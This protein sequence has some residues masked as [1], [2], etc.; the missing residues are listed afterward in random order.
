M[1][2]YDVNLGSLLVTTAIGLI[3]LG[4]RKFYALIHA[5]IQRHD[6]ALDD[7]DD[8]AEILNQHTSLI[9]DAGLVKGPLGI[10][11]VDERRRR[12]RITTTDQ[13]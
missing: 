4:L 5:V 12:N 11:R 8:H 6:Q 7:I 1:I 2:I 13:N 9:V 3:G 10:R